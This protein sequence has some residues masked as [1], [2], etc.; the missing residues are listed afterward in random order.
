MQYQTTTIFLPLIGK[1]LC[2]PAA[3]AV[4]RCQYQRRGFVILTDKLCGVAGFI[5]R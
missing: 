4:I 3:E 5:F 2:D 1:A